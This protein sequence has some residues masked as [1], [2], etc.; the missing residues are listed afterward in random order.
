MH[1]TEDVLGQPFTVETIE[2]APD[3]EGEVTAALVHLPAAHPTDAA[4]LYVH[5]F[6]D[7]FFQRELAHW[8]TDR[9][10]A[11][12]ALDLRKYGRAMRSH[13]TKAYVSDLAQYDE[14][15]DE[16]WTRITQ[17][18]GHTRVIVAAHS[19]G[20]LTTP[21]WASRRRP[22]ELVGM[23]LNSPWLD[24]Q[25]S[26]GQVRLLTAAARIM[27]KISPLK[28]IPREVSG[29]YTR[30]LHHTLDGEWDF[31]LD[32]KPIGSFPVT[33]GWV[34][35]I[36]RGHARVHQG[37]GIDVPILVLASERSGNPTEPGP[38]VHSMDIVLDVRQIKRWAPSLG[39]NMTYV[40]L[41]GA[42]HD[43]VL[44]APVVRA[45]AYAA[46]D[47]WLGA[48]ISTHTARHRA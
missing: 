48:N 37:L 7:Y 3:F 12:Y 32:L 15:L 9:G 21:L 16:A 40:S 47:S 14:E 4:V 10:Y 44:S 17:R 33:F 46:I 18:D 1:V 13:H 6:S 25:G 42:L 43:V 19:T 39:T 41:P 27:A 8:W 38:A 5:G 34:N 45:A 11:F 31:D 28:V 36:R 29:L 35:A 26:P 20:G 2:L 22:K 30:S 23:V 24:M